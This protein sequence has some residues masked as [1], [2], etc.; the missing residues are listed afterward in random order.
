MIMMATQSSTF[1]DGD[2]VICEPATLALQST[3]RICWGNVGD[4]SDNVG[5]SS[6]NVG[7]GGADAATGAEEQ[8]KSRDSKMV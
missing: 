5:E 2:A 8:S 6:D 3:S 7:D 4:A 1:D